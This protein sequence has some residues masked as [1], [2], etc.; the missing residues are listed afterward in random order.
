[1][2]PTTHDLGVDRTTANFMSINPFCVP[3]ALKSQL[4]FLAP[5]PLK[6]YTRY[7]SKGFSVLRDLQKERK[8][9]KVV[10]SV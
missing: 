6:R 4:A 3:L 9:Q 2:I 7:S 1:M 5:L 8:L 10:V